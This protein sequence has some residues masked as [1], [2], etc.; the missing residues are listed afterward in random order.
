VDYE[1]STNDCPDNGDDPEWELHVNHLDDN[2][3]FEPEHY[4]TSYWDGL[5]ALSL[6]LFKFT[7]VYFR[8]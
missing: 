5:T 2:I 7:L 4:V 3:N 6:N 1:Y 8:S